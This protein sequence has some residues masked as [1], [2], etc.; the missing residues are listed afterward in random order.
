MKIDFLSIF[1]FD[2]EKCAIIIIE[3]GDDMKK[4]LF[5]LVLLFLPIVVNAENLKLNSLIVE[6]KNIELKDDIYIYNTT[7]SNGYNVVSIE[8]DAPVG[9]NYEIIGNE[10]LIVGTNVIKINLSDAENT[11]EYVLNVLKM[12]DDVVTLS[13][14]N[15]LK[16][17]S[18]SGYPLGFNP[19]KLEYNLTIK[20]ESRLNIS[21]EKDSELSEVYVTGNEKLITGSVIKIKVIAQSGDVR[22]YKINITASEI[23]E[24]VEIVEENKIDLKLIAYIVSA[25]LISMFLVIINVTGKE[26]KKSKTEKKN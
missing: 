7:V 11:K 23:R 1:S 10:N 4:L 8:V 6:G 17:I 14:N 16:N 15:K 25:A 18:I 20:A 26:E 13:N 3:M 22:E 12:A 19:D 9:V 24:E 2:K 21:Y 5:G